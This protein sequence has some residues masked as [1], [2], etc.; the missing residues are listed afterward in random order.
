MAKINV[1]AAIGAGFG[2]IRRR[3]LTV[4]AWGVLP[5]VLQ[6]AVLLLLAPNLI[7][8]YAQ[9]FQAMAAGG[10]PAPI[11]PPAGL[12]QMQGWVQLVNLGQLLLYAVIYCAVYRAVIRPEQ[13][14]FAYL[15]LG[16]SEFFVMALMFVMFIATFV[17][18]LVI[19][20]PLGI[21]VGIV[22]VVSHSPAVTIAAA[23]PVYLVALV[24]LFYF[25]LRFSLAGPMIVADR[26]FHLFESWT[27]TRGQV[28]RL[29]LVGLGMFGIGLVI[30]TLVLGA[31][32]AFAAAAIFSYGDV[33]QLLASFEK[34][35][36]AVA[37]RFWPFL[38]VYLALMIPVGGVRAGDF[39]CAVG[40]G[41]SGSA[42]RP[43]R[44]VR[45]R[46]AC[47]DGRAG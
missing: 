20:I 47:G 43:R 7:P 32:L 28:G 46:A 14:A 3:P 44:R 9:L 5:V 6:T 38:L 17:G 30:E 2:L 24:A 8:F 39:Q 37:T 11:T 34:A 19:L 25:G 4:L 26:K 35:P 23:L 45:L 36:M 12:M 29:F 31:M 15:R 42:T 10:V 27:A 40:E 33:G 21:I 1:G 18:L 22:A 16:R 41:V 13:S